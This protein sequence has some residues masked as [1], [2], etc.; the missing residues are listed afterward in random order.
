MVELYAKRSKIV[1]SYELDELSPR[2]GHLELSTAAGPDSI[3]FGV[4]IDDVG[5]TWYWIGQW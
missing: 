1:G 2:T 3:T 4:A 5:Q